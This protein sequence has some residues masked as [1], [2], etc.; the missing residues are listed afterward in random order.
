M[1]RETTP[2]GTRVAT[3]AAALLWAACASGGTRA[4]VGTNENAMERDVTIEVQ[5]NLTPSTSVTVLVDDPT[6]NQRL[7]GSVNT[8]RTETFSLDTSTLTAGY[9]LIAQ[10][11][12]G[13]TIRSN[14]VD[15]L[16]SATV[17]WDLEQ[18]LLRVRRTGR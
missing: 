12:D 18:N 15:A 4:E 13:T 17:T 6:E 1:R 3:V 7:L 10:A 9:R 16:G 5:N 14:P 8:D 2:S 11:A